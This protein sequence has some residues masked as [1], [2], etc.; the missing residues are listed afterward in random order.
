VYYLF[1]LFSK[2]TIN[3]FERDSTKIFAPKTFYS[4]LSYFLKATSILGVLILRFVCFSFLLFTKNNINSF[5]SDLAQNI[6]I[7]DILFY[8]YLFFNKNVNILPADSD[9]C[10]HIANIHL[11]KVK[12]VV[13]VV[14]FFLAVNRNECD[15]MS[16]DS[17]SSAPSG[18][19]NLNN[20]L[21]GLLH[22]SLIHLTPRYRGSAGG[23]RH[24]STPHR[25]NIHR[26]DNSDIAP[27]HPRRTVSNSGWFFLWVIICCICC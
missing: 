27:E 11:L 24:S 2:N 26:L 13:V 8:V 3:S 20:S 5:A 18:A 25:S 15:G 6:H 7:Q 19:D 17:V 23:Q 9:L 21:V 14:V 16:D 22:S 1:V 12:G 10:V 4:M